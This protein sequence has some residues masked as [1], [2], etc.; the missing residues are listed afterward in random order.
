MIGQDRFESAERRQRP[1]FDCGRGLLHVTLQTLPDGEVH[2][3]HAISRSWPSF[4]PVPS[5]EK[6]FLTGNQMP[7]QPS[8]IKI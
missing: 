2:C 7:A 5:D 4:P 8:T 1:F 3:P 6:A